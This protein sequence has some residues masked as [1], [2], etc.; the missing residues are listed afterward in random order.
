MVPV[1]KGWTEA[2]EVP[3]DLCTYLCVHPHL[4]LSPSSLQASHACTT[5]S[6]SCAVDVGHPL[7]TQTSSPSSPPGSSCGEL[8]IAQGAWLKH[9]IYLAT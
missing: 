5:Q 3:I 2:A 7:Q 6:A 8:L 1:H 9:K 4:P